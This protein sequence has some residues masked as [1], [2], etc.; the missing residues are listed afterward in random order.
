[1]RARSCSKEDLIRHLKQDIYCRLKPSPVHGIGVFAIRDIDPGTDPFCRLFAQH[2]RATNLTTSEFQELPPPVQRYVLDFFA[3]EGNTFP[4]LS[5]GLNAMD[6][7][8]YL[9]HSDDPNID[10]VPGSGDFYEFRANRPIAAGEE[11]FIDY[12]SKTVK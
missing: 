9:N 7:S 6:L 1:M 12:H 10:Q 3:G 2:D 5:R 8:F 11:L 4:V